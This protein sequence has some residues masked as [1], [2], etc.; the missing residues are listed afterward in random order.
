MNEFY[1][2]P[3]SLVNYKEL[4]MILKINRTT[5]KAL[6]KEGKFPKPF[7]VLNR[8]DRFA[9]KFWV[10]QD[11][12]DFINDKQNGLEKVYQEQKTKVDSKGY[13]SSNYRDKNLWR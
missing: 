11:I 2:N 6:L 8:N 9:K 3:K 7:K 5:I 1:V 4:E 10:Y 13:R 12:I